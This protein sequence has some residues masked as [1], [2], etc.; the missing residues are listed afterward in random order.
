MGTMGLWLFSE[1]V[2]L[3][4]MK[5]S[6]LFPET[7]DKALLS[8]LTIHHEEK[9]GAD[10]KGTMRVLVG[11]LPKGARASRGGGQKGSLSAWERASAEHQSSPTENVPMPRLA[12]LT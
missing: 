3:E 6:G 8:H 10:R 9:W 1:T 12:R 5:E 4:S 11:V 7:E 2:N